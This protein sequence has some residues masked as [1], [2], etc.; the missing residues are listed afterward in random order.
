MCT[1]LLPPGLNP[2]AVNKYIN[3]NIMEAEPPCK[4]MYLNKNKITEVNYMCHL[5][6]HN[7]ITNF[8]TQ[9]L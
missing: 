9:T 3:I 8:H 1:V 4:T 5:Q 2:T 7:L 6:K